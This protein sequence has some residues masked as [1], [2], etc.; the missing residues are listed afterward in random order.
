MEEGKKE[1]SNYSKVEPVP[2]LMLHP[3]SHFRKAWNGL[4]LLLL[5][6]TATILPFQIS[7]FQQG[8][9]GPG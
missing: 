9:P 1:Q 7:F 4:V 3:E 6:H 5:V 2:R 8:A